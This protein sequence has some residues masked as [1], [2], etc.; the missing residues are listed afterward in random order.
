MGFSLQYED[1]L[2]LGLKMR[3]HVDHFLGSQREAALHRVYIRRGAWCHQIVDLSK[4]RHT[5]LRTPKRQGLGRRQIATISVSS[6]HEHVHGMTG[7][8][9]ACSWDDWSKH[10]LIVQPRHF[11]NRAVSSIRWNM[12]KSGPKMALRQGTS[13]DLWGL[14]LPFEI[15][16]QSLRV[17][18]AEWSDFEYVWV[19]LVDVSWL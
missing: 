15:F 9:I 17:S 6:S 18:L 12:L 11:S 7:L 19:W 5:N 2:K 16:P 1:G 14:G 13:S 8:S 10:S 4:P 3:P